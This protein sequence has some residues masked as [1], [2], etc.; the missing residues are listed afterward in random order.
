MYVKILRY[1]CSFSR[2]RRWCWIMCTVHTP[3][4]ACDEC[5]FLHTYV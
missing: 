5:S 1:G 3:C 2:T 4:V